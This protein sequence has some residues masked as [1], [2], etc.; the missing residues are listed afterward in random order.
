MCKKE[1]TGKITR[2]KLKFAEQGLDYGKIMST[3]L[4]VPGGLEQA[5]YIFPRATR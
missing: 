1:Y 4:A 3:A 5:T 2:N